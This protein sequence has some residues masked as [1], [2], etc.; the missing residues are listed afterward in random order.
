MLIVPRTQAA[1]KWFDTLIASVHTVIGEDR[2]DRAECVRIAIL[3]TGVD[4]THPTICDAINKKRIVNLFP[5]SVYRASHPECKLDPLDDRHGHGT[6][7][8]SMLLK[9]APHAKVYVARV[10]DQKGNLIDEDSIVDVTR[11]GFLRL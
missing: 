7:G 5:D 6:H 8:T 4:A 2:K 3:D 11:L 9:T 1:D 10:A